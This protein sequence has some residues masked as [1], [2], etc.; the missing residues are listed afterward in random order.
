MKYRAILLT[1]AR[2]ERAMQVFGN[3]L[4]ALQHWAKETLKRYEDG[5]VQIYEREETL[6]WTITSSQ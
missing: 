6:K 3:D 2:L 4:E 5:I 1:G